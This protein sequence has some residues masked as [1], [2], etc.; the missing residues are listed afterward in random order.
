MDQASTMMPQDTLSDLEFESCPISG[1]YHSGRSTEREKSPPWLHLYDP[2]FIGPWN[3]TE[4][5]HLEP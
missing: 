1:P 4:L 2:A 3:V 5:I